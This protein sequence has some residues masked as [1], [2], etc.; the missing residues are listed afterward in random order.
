[1]KF[2]ALGLDL[3]LSTDAVIAPLPPSI[4]AWV[5]SYRLMYSYPV[6]LSCSI[7]AEERLLLISAES[8]S[9]LCHFPS[10]G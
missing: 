2:C 9:Q 6:L 8:Q 10:R 1:M 3:H 5:L 7:R 4:V